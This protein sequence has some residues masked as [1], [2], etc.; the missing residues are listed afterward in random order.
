[1]ASFSAA[2]RQPDGCT[3]VLSSFPCPTFEKDGVHLSEDSGPK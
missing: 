2:F 1:M 3:Y